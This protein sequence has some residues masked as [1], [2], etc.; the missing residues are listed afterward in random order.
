MTTMLHRLGALALL[1]GLSAL[2]GCA[3]V[4]AP[5]PAVAAAPKPDWAFQASDLPVD[6]AFRFGKLANGM[7][8]VIRRNDRPEGTAV[9]RMDVAAGSLDEGEAERGFAHFVE[10][11]AF[12]GSTHVPEGE[13]VHLLERNGLAFGADTNA[14]T[15]FE[16]TQYKLAL[17]RNDDKLLDTALMLMRETASELTF[18]EDAVKR[19]RGV[20]MSELRDG[21]TYARRN[22]EDQLAFAYPQ[23][24]YPKRLPVGVPATLDQATG[25]SLKAFWAREYTPADTT[26]VVV[27]DFDP[28]AVERLITARFGDWAAKPA[29][30]RPDEGTVDPKQRGAT[31]VY[32]DPALS[33]RVVVARHGTW[34]DEPDTI[35]NR[36]TAILR[37]I[38]YG[39]VNRRL[40]RI[41]RA[42]EPPFRGAGFGT[43]E[44][45][46]IGRTTNLIVDTV[47]GKWRPG[48]IAAGRE[49][50]RALKHGFSAAEVAE[51]VANL[52]TATVNAARS[53]D[54]R[55]NASLAQAVLS[56]IEDEEIPTTPQSV[57][58][59]F[60]AF[61]PQITP[62]A[63]LAAL[64]TEAVKLA[65]PLI[66]FQ[67]RT[68]PEGGEAALRAAWSE[69]MDASL[70]KDATAT[71]L[72]WA[73]AD[74]GR[75][76]TIFQ[77]FVEPQLGIREVR[78]TNGVMLNL[79]KTALEADRVQVSLTIDG[80]SL[81]NTRANPLATEMT[82]FLIQGGLGKHSLDDLQSILAGHTVTSALGASDDAFTARAATT[83]DDLPL[84]L[85]L[86][87]AYL[88][89][90]GY[91]PEGEE[92]YKL[93]IANF[94]AR[95]FATPASALANTQ[96]AILSDN[97]PRF[98]LGTPDQYQALGF[99]KLERD[100]GDRLEHG[101]IEIGIVGDIDE[102][103]TIALVARTFGTLPT[104]EAEFASH[105]E[106]RKRAFAIE[107]GVRL[108]RHTGDPSQAIV[109]AVW[110]TRDDSDPEEAVALEVLERVVRLAVTEGI[111]EKLGQSYSPSA[112]SALS[113]VY[114]GYGTFTVSASVNAGQVAA[115]QQ[116]MEEIVRE[117]R[118]APVSEDVLVRAKAPLAEEY[119]NLL[120]RNAGW[121]V[122]VD[123][124]QSEADRLERFAKMPERLAAVTAADVQ[125]LA[126]R[127]LDWDKAVRILVLPKDA[128]AP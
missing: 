103:E 27:G 5:A 13:M 114:P 51:Q 116:A 31:D 111:R 73:Y 92:Q 118:A 24:T 97:D 62:K 78:F 101:A 15:T 64:K 20:V 52:R 76:G 110:P 65:D 59:R 82:P 91:R 113:R 22:L 43:S 21:L 128:P 106:A 3:A 28:D 11:M 50:R 58:E 53:A 83:P 122:L 112:S 55:S 104:R 16:Q 72:K 40:Q 56:L 99:A 8:Y 18:D 14:F 77:D 19:E 42:S 37:E 34:L 115:T 46:E 47:D 68:T 100:I 61:A 120:K 17:P 69:A 9:V 102:A 7:R 79:K 54:T 36:R 119:A 70:G 98:S 67:G 33:E 88:S 85:E 117:L 44:V 109:R 74:F 84:Q 75:P 60:E 1:A 45:F 108:V 29:T 94:F 127:Y 96:G 23:A 35:A 124:A 125:A 2:A 39:I 26:L 80:G 93:N 107:R 123:R 126:K 121:L 48:L 81:L 57:L 32:V 90:P 6:P 95:A 63:V 86:F 41:S 89:D 49:Y 4:P 38:G 87:T 66:R 25:A 71:E 30:P 10:H 12:N 105:P